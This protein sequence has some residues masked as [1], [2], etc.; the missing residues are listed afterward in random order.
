MLDICNRV[1]TF[2]VIVSYHAVRQH[3]TVQYRIQKKI[4]NWSHGANVQCT[5]AIHVFDQ[6]T[7]IFF[8]TQ[9]S[10]V[11]YTYCM[12]SRY[13][14]AYLLHDSTCLVYSLSV[15]TLSQKV[16]Q[17]LS[18]QRHGSSKTVFLTVVARLSFNA[19][20]NLA[21]LEWNL[22]TMDS[23]KWPCKR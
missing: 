16:P 20:M 5:V 23:Q 11:S 15:G 1:L 22:K 6:M 2:I 8:T 13:R 12:V 3:E 21:N 7:S 9:Q 10:M 4:N 17:I 19:K 14:T 18:T